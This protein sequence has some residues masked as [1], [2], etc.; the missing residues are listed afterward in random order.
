VESG[1]FL[2]PMYS[3]GQQNR[4]FFFLSK[5]KKRKRNRHCFEF[6][7]AC[8]P[9]TNNNNNN[10]NFFL[11]KKKQL[12]ILLSESR[13]PFGVMLRIFLVYKKLCHFQHNFK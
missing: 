1:N 11:K 2:S 9:F 7:V 13:R 3:V 5:K 6:K 12:G 4:I 10:N 8:F